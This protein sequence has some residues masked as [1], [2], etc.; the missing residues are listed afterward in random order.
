MDREDAEMTKLA[1]TMIVGETQCQSCYPCKP[2][3]STAK[4]M[5]KLKASKEAE[6]VKISIATMGTVIN[7]IDK[8]NDKI[9]A[10]ATQTSDSTAKEKAKVKTNENEWRS[11]IYQGRQGFA[12]IR[13]DVPKLLVICPNL[14]DSRV[15][16][17]LL[18]SYLCLR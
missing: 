17:P 14:D 15:F 13:L 8:D 7:E 16:P 18:N 5:T 12:S 10:L 6:F 2:A 9:A 4:K 1:I 3:T 11:L